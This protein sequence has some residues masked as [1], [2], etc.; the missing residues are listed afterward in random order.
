MLLRPVLED[1]GF[2]L[3][4]LQPQVYFCAFRAASAITV[5]TFFG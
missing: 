4:S 5:A 2:G 3:C 1:E